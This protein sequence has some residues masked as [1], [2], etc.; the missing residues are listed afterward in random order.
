MLVAERLSKRFHL[1]RS[2]VDAVRR[3][4][5]PSVVALDDVSLRLAR[6]EVVAVVGE[7]GSGKT[8]LANCIARL[9]DPDDGAIMLGDTDL[10]GATPAELRALR[11]RLQLVYQDPYTSLNPR[12]RIGATIA[13]APLVHGLWRKEEV[14]ERVRHLLEQVGLRPE[15]AERLPRQMSGGQRQ[16]V[17]IAR[18]LALEPEV[19][20]ADE[21]VSALDVSVQA[22]ILGLFERLREE[23]RLGIVFITHQL[24]VVARIADRVAVMYLGRIVEEGPTARVFAEPRHPYTANLLKANPTVDGGRRTHVPAVRGEV[25]SAMD[26]PSGCRFRT[27]CPLAQPIC[28]EVDPPAVELAP[29]HVSRCHVLAPAAVAARERSSTR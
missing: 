11:P 1:R 22:Q 28:T 6:D 7:S 23:R 9:V 18:A 27:R 21:A 13:E 4:P 19:L 17:A 24:P 14:G 2:L 16:R 5:V 12:R 25:P 3:R 15:I 20:I 10:L 29:G 26:L 8:T